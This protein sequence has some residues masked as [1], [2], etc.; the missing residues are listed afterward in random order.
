MLWYVIVCMVCMYVWYVLYVIVCI[1]NSRMLWLT[2]T[3]GKHWKSTKTMIQIS[4]FLC[5][6]VAKAIHLFCRVWMH[7]TKMEIS[8]YF[9]AFP[10]VKK[11]RNPQNFNGVSLVLLIKLGPLDL[12]RYAMDPFASSTLHTQ[13]NASN[14]RQTTRLPRGFYTTQGWMLWWMIHKNKEKDAEHTKTRTTECSVFLCP[15][16][17][18]RRSPHL[19][20]V[21]WSQISIWVLAFQVLLMSKKIVDEIFSPT[22]VIEIFEIYSRKKSGGECG[23]FLNWNYAH[24]NAI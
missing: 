15:V 5:F 12:W 10:S 17:K 6:R 13:N 23:N 7:I 21:C 1:W 4:L 11:I 24:L 8:K 9:N 3:W 2:E 22:N 16:S 18:G 19:D 14:D 20:I